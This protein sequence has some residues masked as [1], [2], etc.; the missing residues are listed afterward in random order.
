MKPPLL[1]TDPR[2]TAS[3]KFD[4]ACH[5]CI[6]YLD[7][8]GPLNFPARHRISHALLS[9]ADYDPSL[10]A[11]YPTLVIAYAHLAMPIGTLHTLYLHLTHT[12]LK[13]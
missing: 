8:K 3:A 6:N 13:T 12:L 7:C 2:D 1:S 11:P 5:G 4:I 10:S 9:F